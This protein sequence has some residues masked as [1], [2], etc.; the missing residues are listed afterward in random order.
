[1]GKSSFYG[2]LAQQAVDMQ[3]LLMELCERIEAMRAIEGP[4]LQQ[5]YMKRVGPLEETVLQDELE[6]LLLNKKL[7][8]IQRSINRK[9]KVDLGQIEQMLQQVRSEMLQKL[10]QK[11]GEW[12]K[13]P[14]LSEEELEQLRE[15]FHRIAQEF[16]PQTHPGL[17]EAEKEMYR[18]ALE[19]YRRQD[20]KELLVIQ[21]ILFQDQLQIALSG[22]IELD[23][24]TTEE[25]KEMEETP[26]WDETAF[27]ADYTLVK[28]LYPFFAPGEADAA[29]KE[30]EAEFL[31]QVRETKTQMDELQ[32]SFPFNAQEVLNDPDKM[33]KH[34][35]NLRLRQAT[36]QQQCQMLNRKIRMLL[37]E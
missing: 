21:E 33:E 5:E 2:W 6:A 14:V 18:R 8:L 1:M 13:R 12:E 27:D 23:L 37:E 30:I 17:N 4:K 11:R 10:E 31:E 36:A 28:K 3:A 35:E 16:H 15:A 32:N 7:E 24:T 20:L 19:A 9:E 34:L 29:L 25:V 22:K 26:E